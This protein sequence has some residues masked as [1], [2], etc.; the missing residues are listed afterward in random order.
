MTKAHLPAGQVH[1]GVVEVVL[2]QDALDRAVVLDHCFV[3]VEDAQLFVDLEARETG[4]FVGRLAHRTDLGE[5]IPA[6]AKRTP[7]FSLCL[8]RGSRL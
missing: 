2:L 4:R 8:A 5:Q 7:S 3:Q 6:Q 1:A